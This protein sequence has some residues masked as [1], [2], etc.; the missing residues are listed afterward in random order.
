MTDVKPIYLVPSKLS[1]P[2]S[3]NFIVFLASIS[4]NALFDIPISF[5]AWYKVVKV[6]GYCLMSLRS[7]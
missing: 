6:I 3:Y 1:S 7:I 5:E 4:F 2:L